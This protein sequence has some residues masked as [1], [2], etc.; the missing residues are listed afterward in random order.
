[1]K[2][3]QITPDTSIYLQGLTSIAKPPDKLYYM[4]TLP[5]ERRPTL[6]VIGTRKPTNYG[7][8]VV[9]SLVSS[10]AKHGVIIVSG[11]ALGMD[12]LAHQTALEAGGTAL[13]IIPST[14]PRI[15][16]ATNR[17]L[18]ERIIQSG[19]AI[20]SEHGENDDDY[21]VGKWSFLERNRLVAGISDAVLII[22]A[23][24]RSGTMNTAMYALEQGKDVFVVPGNITSPQSGGCNALIKQ[25]ALP[26]TDPDDI[27]EKL[28]PGYRPSQTSLPLGTNPTEVAILSALQ[29]GLRDADEIQR[30]TNIDPTDLSMAL[31]MLEISGSIKALG[32][33]MW[34]V[35]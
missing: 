6:A 21:I 22:E 29:S 1:M 19:G 11:L 9:S 18:A 17:D 27:L 25:G 13:A 8:E 10:I 7:K 24:V 26:V 16:P 23:S 32:G 34:R 35:N 15:V 33:N 30:A 31:T 5:A 14:L 2:I 12:A 4:G 3:N 28:L 20:I